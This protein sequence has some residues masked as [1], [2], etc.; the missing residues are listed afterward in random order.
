MAYGIQTFDA[1]GAL[2]WDSSTA[3][4]GLV[5]D[6]VKVAA[7]TAGYTINYPQWAGLAALLVDCGGSHENVSLNASGSYPVVTITTPPQD[8]AFGLLV[9]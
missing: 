1:S 2:M 7:G 9:Y 4:G 5:G 6:Y 8:I 3:V